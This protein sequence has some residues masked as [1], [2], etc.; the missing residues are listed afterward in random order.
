M[1]AVQVSAGWPA[2][3]RMHPAMHGCL[4]AAPCLPSRLPASAARHNP[5]WPR[6]PHCHPAAALAAAH[7][8]PAHNTV[9]TRRGNGAS[10]LRIV[11]YAAIH[12]SSY[13]YYKRA[14]HAA[15]DSSW[16]AVQ[17]GRLAS[18]SSVWDLLA[19]GLSGATAVAA[20]Y[21]L[22]LVRTRL[23]WATEWA[24]ECRERA[25]NALGAAAHPLGEWMLGQKVV[26]A[27]KRG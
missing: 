18:S 20:T 19:G 1:G 14:I 6:P 5:A 22:D 23:A 7:C 12:F 15:A 9:Y 25:A 8:P 10:V 17:G 24:G 3:A 4:E 16:P 26:L 27:N 21:P 11:P 13:E 2:H